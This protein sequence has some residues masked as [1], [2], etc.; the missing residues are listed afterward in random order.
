MWFESCRVQEEDER[1]WHRGR[2][3]DQPCCLNLAEYKK[4]MKEAGIEAESMINHVVSVLQE[5][6]KKVKEAGIEAESM[7]NHVV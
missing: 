1:S 6:K 3:L 7:I 4:K 5:Y 2:K